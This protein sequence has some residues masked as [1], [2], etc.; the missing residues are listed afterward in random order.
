MIFFTRLCCSLL[1]L[2]L[3][4]SPAAAGQTPEA[5]LTDIQKAIDTHDIK[6]FE[7]RV[8]IDALVT[9]GA[10]TLVSVLRQSASV[11]TSGLPPMLALMVASVQDPGMAKQITNLLVSEVGTFTRSGVSSGFFAGKKTGAKPQGLLAPLLSDA[12]TG[13]KELRA[14]GKSKRMDGGA[15]LPVTIH[16]FGNGRDYKADLFLTPSGESWQV[17]RIANMNALVS[18]LKKESA[19]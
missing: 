9:Q 11:E 17:T 19:E 15:L 3:L 18:R 5:A 1:A 4:S 16:D 7:Q 13:R 14:R 2:L 8:A 12:S 6:L 10:E